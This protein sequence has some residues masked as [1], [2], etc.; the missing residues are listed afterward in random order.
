GVTVGT[1]GIV[2]IISANAVHAA[3]VG[4]AVTISTTAT[5]AG[6]AASTST[7][8]AN[9]KTIAMTIMQKTFITF[10]I[11]ASVGTGIY[12]ARQASQMREHNQL[13]HQQQASIN[14]QLQQL[15]HKHDDSTKRLA[16]L[17]NEIAT[18]KS[19]NSELLKLR[20]QSTQL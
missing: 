9:T 12:E 7:I 20:A 11:V 13:L 4:L 2:A 5:L 1:A 6:T 19:N 15:Q 3:P 10:V 16:A 17:Q 8:I 14:D 18:L